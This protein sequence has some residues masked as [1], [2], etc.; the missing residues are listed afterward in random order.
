MCALATSVFELVAAMQTQKGSQC[1]QCV[2]AR[3]QR[4]AA[5]LPGDDIFL[6]LA[7]EEP[8]AEHSGESDVPDP[9]GQGEGLPTSS[10]VAPPGLRCNGVDILKQ[11]AAQE[12]QLF[13]LADSV[14]S[15]VKCSKADSDMLSGILR[16]FEGLK[17]WPPDA[18]MHTELIDKMVAL[19][20]A[21]PPLLPGLQALTS[22]DGLGRELRQLHEDTDGLHKHVELM[23]SEN[24][25]NLQDLRNDLDTLGKA[26]IQKLSNQQKSAIPLPRLKCF[27]L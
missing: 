15:L 3:D 10:S 1:F 14:G 12:R 8:E 20:S 27:L 9:V 22:I 17:A 2:S 4:P 24:K 11:L 16:A 25:C 23:R 6:A 21:R 26:V 19:T 7:G 13:G 5:S 18:M